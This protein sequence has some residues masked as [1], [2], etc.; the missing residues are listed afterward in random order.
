MFVYQ[1]NHFEFIMIENRDRDIIKRILILQ[2]DL[3]LNA[4][5]INVKE[6]FMRQQQSKDS[7]G[8][9]IKLRKS[10]YWIVLYI[11]KKLTRTVA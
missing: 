3:Y 1:I 7:E 2:L 4:L 9:E 5:P 10:L 11:N 6:L 8:Y